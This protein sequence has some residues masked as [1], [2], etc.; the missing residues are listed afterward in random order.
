[1]KS[2]PAKTTM[3]EEETSNAPVATTLGI[4]RWVQTSF[5]FGAALLF[6]LLGQVVRAIWDIF[7]EPDP[8]LVAPIAGIVAV[9]TAVALYRAPKV[10]KFSFEVATELSKVS[11]PNRQET[12]KQTVVVI[13]VSV[14]AA[15]ILGVFDAIWLAI[16]NLVYHFG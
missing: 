14:I 4:D 8:K 1:M 11:W 16:T 7:A 10:H 13:A 2:Q 5:I 6:M 15:I 9:V 3:A 12:W